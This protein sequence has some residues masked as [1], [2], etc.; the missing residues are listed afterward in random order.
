MEGAQQCYVLLYV[1]MLVFNYC[2]S[3]QIQDFVVQ[4]KVNKELVTLGDY[5]I[6]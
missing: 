6:L 5:N 2:N 1:E 4:L 3:V